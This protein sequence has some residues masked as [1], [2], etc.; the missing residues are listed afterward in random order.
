[1]WRCPH[2]SLPDHR[3]HSVSPPLPQ[4]C[5]PPLLMH[6]GYSAPRHWRFPGEA[7][8]SSHCTGF[9]GGAVVKNQPALAGEARDLGLIPW[10]GRS[11]E[12]GNGNQLQCSCLENSMDRGAWR[13][14]V[15]GVTQ[16]WTR[17]RTH[18]G[19]HYSRAGLKLGLHLS[20]PQPPTHVTAHPTAIDIL[21]PVDV[22]AGTLHPAPLTAILSSRLSPTPQLWPRLCCH[23]T[24]AHTG[25]T[26]WSGPAQLLLSGEWPVLLSGQAAFCLASSPPASHLSRLCRELASLLRLS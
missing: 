17:Q 10:S 5:G 25:S 11:P 12:E 7:E 26:S 9:P 13:A 6:I 2:Q 8:S 20:P 23:R 14:T 1:M 24:L 15:L 21:S 16:S 19:S 4:T 18:V 22:Q 3:D